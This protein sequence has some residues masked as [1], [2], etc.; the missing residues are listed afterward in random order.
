MS[1]LSGITSA[2][3]DV[4]DPIKPLVSAG[5]SLFGGLSTNS[6]NAAQS[7]NQMDFQE[8]M[9]NTAYQRAMKDMKA[10]GLNPMLAYQQGGAST[11]TGASAT[12]SD[13]VTPAINSGM[14]MAQNQATLENLRAQNDQIKSQT[15]L[16]RANSAAALASAGVSNAMASKTNVDALRI[17]QDTSA[18]KPE[19]DYKLL[20]S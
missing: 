16:N 19:A 8:R 12:L 1:F 3:G 9:S 7:Q 14:S 4:I 18:D 6:A 15:V 17:K 11:P 10:A 13:P 20:L 5:A 2:I